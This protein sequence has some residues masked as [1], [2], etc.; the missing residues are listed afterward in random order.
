MEDVETLVAETIQ[1]LD[2]DRAQEAKH[3][4]MSVD[5]YTKAMDLINTIAIEE[6]GDWAEITASSSVQPSAIVMA[7]LLMEAL[8]Q[9]GR[10]NSGDKRFWLEVA[11]YLGP[12]WIAEFRKVGGFMAKVDEF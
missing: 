10:M 6:A 12:D 9:S 8:P 3:F 7:Q 2:E 4:A 11:E 1:E 5:E